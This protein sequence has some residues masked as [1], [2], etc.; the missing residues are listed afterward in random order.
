M[1]KKKIRK[2]SKKN[3][4]LFKNCTKK[5]FGDKSQKKNLFDQKIRQY[6]PKIMESQIEEKLLKF[7]NFYE[8]NYQTQGVSTWMVQNPI[9]IKCDYQQKYQ[10]IYCKKQALG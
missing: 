8:K 6:H 1:F 5:R 7:K 3:Y 10:R 2:K 9:Q 4:F